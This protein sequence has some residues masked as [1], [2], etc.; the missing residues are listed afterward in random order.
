MRRTL[1]T[2]VTLFLGGGLLS[3]A[4]AHDTWLAPDRY[5]LSRPAPVTLSL[6]SGME[7]PKLDHAIRSERV[8][9]AKQ[10]SASGTSEL[11]AGSEGRN[12]LDL[13][14]RAAEPGV[15]TY[16]VVLHPRPS[17]LRSDQVR[18]YVA[19]LGL[20][21]PAAV[22]AAWERD[23]A[24]PVR[25]NYTKFAKSFVRVNDADAGGATGQAGMALEIVPV[26]DPTTLSPGGTLRVRV[27][28][29]G[30][31]LTDYPLELI[32]EGKDEPARYRTDGAGGAAIELPSPGRYMLRASTLRPAA[33]GEE[34]QWDVDFSTM[35]FAVRRATA[36][37]E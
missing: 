1:F 29:D 15:T 25:Y 9:L 20:A 18:E 36:V 24:G 12:A 17:E 34:R 11:P 31:P 21:D 10:R 28:R 19:H 33:P 3:A 7:F 27:L 5:H 13:K 30:A 32:R 26:E 22:L 4:A 2:L 16:W 14:A 37:K 35:T 6:T 23:G 8:A